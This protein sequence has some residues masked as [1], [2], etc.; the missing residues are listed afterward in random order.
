MPTPIICN[1]SPYRAVADHS[2]AAPIT[3]STRPSACVTQLASSSARDMGSG[4][5]DDDIHTAITCPHWRRRPHGV[6]C[7]ISTDSRRVSERFVKPSLARRVSNF[8]IIVSTARPRQASGGSV[9]RPAAR[10][11]PAMIN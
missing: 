5:V 1:E 7:F 4:A 11:P 6:D 3:A 8:H 9:G 10:P 2:A